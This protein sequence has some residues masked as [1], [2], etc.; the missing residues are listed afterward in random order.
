M[1]TKEDDG[2]YIDVPQN[3]YAK[4]TPTSPIQIRGAFTEGM[5]TCCSIVLSAMDP[6]HTQGYQC[7]CHADASTDLSDLD[8]GIPRWLESIGPGYQINLYFDADEENKAE[9]EAK[10][11][12]A[13]EQSGLSITVTHIEGQGISAVVERN[14]MGYA[15]TDILDS[16]PTAQSNSGDVKFLIQG[17]VQA[18]LENPT[19]RAYPPMCVCDS[20]PL[21]STEIIQ[22]YPEQMQIFALHWIKERLKDMDNVATMPLTEIQS[23]FALDRTYGIIKEI[24]QI[25]RM[26]LIGCV[27]DCLR[28]L[29]APQLASL[30]EQADDSSL[31]MHRAQQKTMRAHNQQMRRE[32][33]KEGKDRDEG[34]NNASSRSFGAK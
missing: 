23:T 2:Y 9:F 13:I 3:G 28:E 21:S 19:L 33:K 6:T 18:A 29:Q 25:N 11:R 26:S 7:L 34:Q 4:I 17:F 1:D 22:R 5:N 15:A 31:E 14:T 20:Y 30:S 27:R 24:L 8:H 32:D 16:A 10:I 12:H